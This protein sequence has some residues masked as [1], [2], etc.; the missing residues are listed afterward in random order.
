MNNTQFKHA[1]MAKYVKELQENRFKIFVYSDSD[2]IDFKFEKDN[3][4]GYCMIDGIRGFTFSSVHKPNNQTGRGF[5]TSEETWNPTL[6]DA[7]NAFCNAPYWASSRDRKSIEKY[8]N[9]ADYMSKE[10]VLKYRELMA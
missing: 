7:E 10:T 6:K 2:S 9:M 4:L 5:R 1:E 3:N 8:K